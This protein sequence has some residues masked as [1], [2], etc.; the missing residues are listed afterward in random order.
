M[1][2]FFI[3]TV[4]TLTIGLSGYAQSK[5]QC[6]ANC[7]LSN[8]TS[9]TAINAHLLPYK[10]DDRNL[11]SVSKSWRSLYFT[12]HF[13]KN[14]NLF[15][16]SDGP[17]NTFLGNSAGKVN[18]GSWNVAIGDSAMF[19]NTTGFNNTATGYHALYSNTEGESNAAYGFESLLSN[20]T[21]FYNSAFGRG[22][23]HN[24]NTGSMNTGNGL[25]VL[26]NNT[27][28][29]LNVASGAFSLVQNT[30]GSDN[31]AIGESALW[32]N[33]TNSFN[34]GIGSNAGGSLDY[35]NATFVGAWTAS[36]SG[37]TNISAVGY[38]AY[39]TASNQ[40]VLGNSAVTSIGGYANWS[41]FSDGRYKKNVKE[42]VPGLEFIAQLRPVTY[43]LDVDGIESSKKN[44][45]ERK[46]NINIPG[47]T[48]GISIPDVA[49]EKSEKQKSQELKS[50]QEKAQVIYTG[51][52]AQEVEQAAKKLN[53]DFSGVDAPKTEKNFYALRYG[54]FIVPLVKAVQEQQKQIDEQQK[55][56][57]ELKTLLQSITK[58][59]VSKTTNFPSSAA[60]LK[61]NTPNPF[62]NGTV[63]RY[64]IPENAGNAQIIVTDMKGS[65][66]RTFAVTKGEGQINI[67][68]A[69]LPSAT[70]NY[71]LLINGKKIDSKQMIL[72]K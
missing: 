2:Q 59:A 7:E 34:T 33:T 66:I 61:Q 71:A 49:F 42:D 21:G 8:L 23:M 40:V 17:G 46:R 15:L 56:I 51:F 37:L 35:S 14:G 12:G 27:E 6:F 64:Y 41:N 29:W 24:T 48:D 65:L 11:G 60:F 36:D 10:N 43:T 55:Q 20:T 31:T 16:S 50:K 32:T 28:G 13:Y 68:S 38:E 3:L 1:K 4:A 54:D 26:Y 30:W 57:E 58:Q 69:E 52:I 53:Y 25:G 47:L 70:Y 67:N 44:A 22:S 19:S 45:V 63:I 39:A 18:D 72:T 9:P 62:D 5:H